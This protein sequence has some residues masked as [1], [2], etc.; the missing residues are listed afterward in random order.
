M[1]NVQL[2]C[3]AKAMDHA[4]ARVRGQS[5]LLSTSVE[6]MQDSVSDQAGY[7]VLKDR[8]AVILYRNDLVC[9]AWYNVK[10]TQSSTASKLYMGQRV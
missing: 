10:G 1:E 8:N 6:T 9:T 4:P 3:Y 7:V 2:G 5:R